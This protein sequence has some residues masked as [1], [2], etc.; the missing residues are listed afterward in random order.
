[1]V[2]VHKKILFLKILTIKSLIILLK[3]IWIG[4]WIEQEAIINCSR[5]WVWREKDGPW[6]CVKFCKVA[7][8][9]F[10]PLSNY[11]FLFNSLQSIYKSIIA[12]GSRGSWSNRRPIWQRKKLV[13]NGSRV[14]NFQLLLFR[15]VGRTWLKY[16]KAL[17]TRYVPPYLF[18]IWMIYSLLRM[19]VIIHQQLVARLQVHLRLVYSTSVCSING[20][21]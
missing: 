13:Y 12:Y 2:T 7:S 21:H 10:W 11:R 8:R 15:K 3:S 19:F 6:V 1:M 17:V 20:S 18:R 14:S 16:W 5:G 4:L 9:S